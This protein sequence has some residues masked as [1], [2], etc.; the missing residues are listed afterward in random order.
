MPTPPK[1]SESR[2]KFLSRCIPYLIKE[3]KPNDQAAAICMSMYKEASKRKK[4]KGDESEPN[5]DDFEGE[6]WIII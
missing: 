5:W 2:E 6:N 1:N 4:S 3:G